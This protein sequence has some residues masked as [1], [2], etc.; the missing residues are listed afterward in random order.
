MGASV[1][2]QSSS[3][4]PGLS[5]LVR[6]AQGAWILIPRVPWPSVYVKEL[7][8]GVLVE[9]MGRLTTPKL[10]YSCYHISRKMGR[11]SHS[12]IPYHGSLG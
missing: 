2:A 3:P 4:V 7:G 9:L 11:G 6:R 10:P 8:E 1:V 5:P 12:P